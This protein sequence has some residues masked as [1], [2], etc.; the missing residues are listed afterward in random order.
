VV[1]LQVSIPVSA[2][3]DLFIPYYGALRLTDYERS[4]GPLSPTLHAFVWSM[5]IAVVALALW[6]RRVLV[7]T[8][9]SSRDLKRLRTA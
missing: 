4:P 1:G 9:A 6:R 3:A 8:S 7:H 5:L 2:S